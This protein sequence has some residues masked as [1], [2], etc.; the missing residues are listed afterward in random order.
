MLSLKQLV[1]DA[2]ATLGAPLLLCKTAA[3][4]EYINGSPTNKRDGTRYTVAAPAA[5]M[6]A[7]NVKVLGPQA[8][9]MDGK[10]IVPVDFD[11]LD[12]YIYF[13]DGKPMVAARAKGVHTVDKL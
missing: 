7:I 5:G 2:G 12:V 11:A 6:A 9:E 8:V 1:I 3:T 13:K 10:S 4:F